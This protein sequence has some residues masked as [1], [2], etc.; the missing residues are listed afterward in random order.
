L[1]GTAGEAGTIGEGQVDSGERFAGPEHDFEVA[2]DIE[3]S[4]D[5]GA[6]QTELAGR[7]QHVDDGRGVAE[8][9]GGRAVGGGAELAAV[10]EANGYRWPRETSVPDAAQQPLGDGRDPP[11]QR[12]TERSMLP[13]APVHGRTWRPTLHVLCG[14]LGF[15]GDDR[16][17]NGGSLQRII[18]VR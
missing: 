1:D 6:G 7:A 15:H 10:P 9:D 17:G 11:T 14:S 16:P 4:V 18:R 8:H 13:P 2:L 3:R 12:G 5:P